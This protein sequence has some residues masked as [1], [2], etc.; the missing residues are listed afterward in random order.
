MFSTYRWIKRI[1]PGL[2]TSS[3]GEITRLF[4]L[5]YAVFYQQRQVQKAKI[6]KKNEMSC[7]KKII[8]KPS[9]RNRHVLNIKKAITKIKNAYF[10]GIFCFSTFSTCSTNTAS[11]VFLV[12]FVLLIGAESSFPVDISAID[13][14]Y[15]NI[16][17]LFTT[18]NTIL[19]HRILCPYVSFQVKNLCKQD[20][21]GMG[22]YPH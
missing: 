20:R 16:H 22:P 6:K 18:Y 19:F 4:H 10:T 12:I 2:S 17:R 13:D 8:N 14:M 7:L 21:S 11:K 15:P 5:N 1:F 9:T 3:C